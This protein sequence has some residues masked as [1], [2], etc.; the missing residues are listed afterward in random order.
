LDPDDQ[1]VKYYDIL[2]RLFMFF[3][4]TYLDQEHGF[5]D[6]RDEERTAYSH[7]TTRMANFDAARYLCQW[8]R[9]AKTVQLPSGN[10]KI[11]PPRTSGRF[12]IFDKSNRKEQGLFLYRDAESGLHLQIPLDQLRQ[13]AHERRR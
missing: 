4:E 5:L 9:L 12:V 11:E 6:L 2:R 10:P 1:K 8:S 3:Y 13:D 7:H